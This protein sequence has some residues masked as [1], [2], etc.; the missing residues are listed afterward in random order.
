M[1]FEAWA[2]ILFLVAGLAALAGFLEWREW[3]N[4]PKD[5]RWENDALDGARI[6]DVPESLIRAELAKLEQL[7]NDWPTT[8]KKDKAP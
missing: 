1:T 4:P 8:E 6:G 5:L 2:V 3:K 7:N